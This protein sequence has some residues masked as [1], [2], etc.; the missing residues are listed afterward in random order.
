MWGGEEVAHTGPGEVR[1][2]ARTKLR[3]CQ[4]HWAADKSGAPT[5]AVPS[6][7]LGEWEFDAAVPFLDSSWWRPRGKGV[8][9]GRSLPVDLFPTRVLLTRRRMPALQPDVTALRIAGAKPGVSNPL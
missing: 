3:G 6:C 1:A 5:A 4:N 8:A 9:K 2:T 7:R